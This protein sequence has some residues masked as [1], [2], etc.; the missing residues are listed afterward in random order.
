LAEWVYEAGIGENRAALVER[1]H[2]LEMAV[3]RD[4]ERGP[5]LGAILS[6]RLMRKADQSGRGLVTFDDGT[7]AQITPVPVGMTEG[8]ALTVEVVRETL[9]EGAEIKPPRVRAALAGT[10]PTIGLDLH[11]RIAASGLPIRIPTADADVLEDH[12]WSEAIEQAGSGIITT[13]NVL[14][15]ISPT[16]AMTLIDIDGAGSAVD[17][18]IAGA[19][20]A[21]E[22][23]RRFG[24]TGSIGIDLPTLPGK[25]ERQ[26]AAAAL[27]AVLP[28]PFERTAVNGFGFLQIIRRRERASLIEQLTAD[29]VRTAALSLLRRGARAGGHG[30]LVLQAHPRVAGLIATRPDWIDALG[31]EIGATIALRPDEA[32][33]ISAGHASRAFP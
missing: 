14:L 16:P 10:A 24:I 19:R 17:V 9:R 22:A 30:E 33:A 25:A 2:I 26:A 27:D 12:G 31:R 7:T 3:E 11:A 6:A 32:L 20:A 18:A 1:G 23:I 5:R 4:D 29:P 8:A 13:P 21:G 28:P 15:R